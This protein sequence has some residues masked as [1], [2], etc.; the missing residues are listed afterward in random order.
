MCVVFVCSVCPAYS[1]FNDAVHSCV[2][3]SGVPRV[4]TF[5]IRAGLLWF[6]Q[7]EHRSI[8]PRVFVEYIGQYYVPVVQAPNRVFEYLLSKFIG[9][10]KYKFT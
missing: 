10:K 8:V 2:P 4:T 3:L 1:R 7:R 9:Y 6:P 5:L